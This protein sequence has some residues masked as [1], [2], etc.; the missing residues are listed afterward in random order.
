MPTTIKLKNSV[1]TTNAPSSLA[2]GEVAINVTDKKVWVGNAATTPVQLLG[3]GASGN[4]SALTVA[5]TLTMTGDNSI[6]YDLTTTGSAKVGRNDRAYVQF[7]RNDFDGILSFYTTTSGSGGLTERMRITDTGNVGIGTSSPVSNRQLTLYSQSSTA[8]LALRTGTSGVATTDGAE[9]SFGSDN[10]IYITNREAGNIIL[11]ANG[12]ERM[13]LD[14]SGNLGIGTT[15]PNA[16]LALKSPSASGD[17]SMFEIQAAGSASKLLKMVIN[18]GADVYTFGTDI[19]GSLA[20]QTN[21]TERMR[22]DSSGN[23]LVGRTAPDSGEKFNV[24]G[25]S[26]ETY[27]AR[28]YH[29]GDNS[30]RYGL[31]IRCGTNNASGTN[32]AMAFDDGDGTRQGQITFSG[33][34]TTYGTSS[35]YRLKENIVPI[36]NVLERLALLKPCKWNW[37]R[38]GGESEGFVAHELQKV[39]PIAVAGEKDA[40]DAEGNPVYQSVGAANIVPLLTAAIQEQQAIINDLKSRI[41]TLESK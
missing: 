21:A 1:T 36:N 18:Q 17:Q 22:I 23:L 32:F 28:F 24:T 29:Q 11:E 41:E 38:D 30:N 13:R 19:A 15:S 7:T 9:F 5:G 25:N 39:V 35:D 26:A 37:K 8:G 2:Q 12:S 40:V 3:T 20:F 34:T 33:G 6:D 10:N 16:K 31:I 4:F 27:L 14:A